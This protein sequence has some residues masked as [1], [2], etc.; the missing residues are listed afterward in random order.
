MKSAWIIIAL[1]IIMGLVGI[2]A[3]VMWIYAL[4]AYG[5]RPITEIPS[6]A[7]VFIHNAK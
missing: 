6:W 1:Y 7:Y 3:L 5:G 2:G 4:I